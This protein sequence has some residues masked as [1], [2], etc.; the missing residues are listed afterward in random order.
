MATNVSGIAIV[1]RAFLPTGKTLDEQFAALSLVKD[2]H[3]SGDYST[4]LKAAQIDEVKTEQKVRRVEDAPVAAPEPEAQDDEPTVQ[5]RFS[6]GLDEPRT[7]PEENDDIP[8]GGDDLLDQEIPAEREPDEAA[9][10]RRKR[11]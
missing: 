3:A 4:L 8:W 5:N 10:A 9:P 7:E 6:H 2:A 1:I 11:A